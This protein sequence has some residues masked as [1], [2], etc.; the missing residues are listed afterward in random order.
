MNQDE[1]NNSNPKL[2]LSN[3]KKGK[4]INIMT[5]KLNNRLNLIRP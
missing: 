5:I 2:S 1:R 3:S 4:T